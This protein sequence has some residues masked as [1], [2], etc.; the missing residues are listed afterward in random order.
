[1]NNFTITHTLS[2]TSESLHEERSSIIHSAVTAAYN[3]LPEA[4]RKLVGHVAIIPN[5]QQDEF[6]INLI[7]EGISGRDT[8]GHEKKW[9]EKSITR[10][11]FSF[12]PNITKDEICQRILS[13][14]HKT[15]FSIANIENQCAQKFVRL[16]ES[17]TL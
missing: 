11:L 8:F 16:A 14:I 17:I 12:T 1:V 5:V 15:I 2:E 7:L 9:K 4:V 13:E 6:S 3:K 10:I